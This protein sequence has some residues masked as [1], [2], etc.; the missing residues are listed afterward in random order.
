MNIIANPQF[1]DPYSRQLHRTISAVFEFCTQQ[2][3]HYKDQATNVLYHC[4]NHEV[5]DEPLYTD[6]LNR[7]SLDHTQLARH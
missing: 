4:Q 2:P 6:Q 3:L 5:S 1:S 7:A